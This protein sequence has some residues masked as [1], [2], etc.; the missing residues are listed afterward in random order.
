MK[1][2]IALFDIGKTNKKVLL[3]D[4]ELHLVGQNEQIFDEVTDDDDAIDI[5]VETN[6]LSD[7]QTVPIFILP[8]DLYTS[9]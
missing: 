9:S 6:Q 8:T 3:F 7:F 1:D 4:D 5:T 2:V